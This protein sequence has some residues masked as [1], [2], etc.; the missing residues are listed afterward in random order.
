M[1]V[2]FDCRVVGDVD[3]GCELRFGLSAVY[4]LSRRVD[5]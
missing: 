5:V 1:L 2:E 4:L 3:D